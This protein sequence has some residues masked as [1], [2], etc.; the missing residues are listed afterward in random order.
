MRR[1]G[2]GHV[3][4]GEQAVRVG[5]VD[6]IGGVDVACNLAAEAVGLGSMYKAGNLRV[7]EVHGAPISLESATAYHVAD[8]FATDLGDFA[9]FLSRL[10]SGRVAATQALPR[11]ELATG[12][13]PPPGLDAG[14]TTTAALALAGGMARPTICAELPPSLARGL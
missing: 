3:W 5:L 2:N 11:G 9:A 10:L 1:A 6:E 12:P 7:R 4:I 8:A 14:A 13:A